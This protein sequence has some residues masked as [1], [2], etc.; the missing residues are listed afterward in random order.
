M[1]G[2]RAGHCAGNTMPGDI[3]QMR[4]FGGRGGQGAGRGAGLGRGPGMGGGRGWRNMFH[5]TGLPGWMRFGQGAAPTGQDSAT[6]EPIVNERAILEQ[7]AEA[8]KLQL[9]RVNQSL[10]EL[11]A[12]SPSPK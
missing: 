5:L 10:S 4:G 11:G 8:L 6:P 9:E 2:R 3:N 7:Q 1:T 12:S